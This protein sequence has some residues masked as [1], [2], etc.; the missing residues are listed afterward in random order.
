MI[1]RV[2][3]FLALLLAAESALAGE[4]NTGWDGTLYGYGSRTILNGN[5]LLNPGNR[6]AALPEWSSVGELRLNLKAGNEILHLDARPIASLRE[7]RN[8]FGSERKSDIYL[9]RWQARLRLGDTW[10]MAGGREVMNWGPAQFRSPSSPFYFDSGRSD[11]M[12][13]LTGMDMAKLVWTPDMSV[14]VTAAHIVRSGKGVSSPDVWKKS[15]LAKFDQRGEAW[16]YALIVAKAEK[17]TPYYGGYAHFTPDDAWMLYGETSWAALAGIANSRRRATTLAGVAYTFESGQTLNFEY[18]HD[19]HGFTAAERDV[20]FQLAAVAPG[21]ALAAMPRLMGRDY[22]HLVWQSNLMDSD[23]YWRL[24]AT[25]NL[26]DHGSTLAGYG[27][28]AFAGRYSLFATGYWNFG[29]TRQGSAALIRGAITAGL[30][31]AMP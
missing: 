1:L 26:S 28:L 9:S 25:H 31:V 15:W 18:L 4:W 29:N 14:S 11:P 22:L 8:V 2:T 6:I 21:A 20:Y 27:E 30:K 19:G 17:Q 3:F 23:G 24:M 10:S 5:S 12:R 16:V 7:N 13:E